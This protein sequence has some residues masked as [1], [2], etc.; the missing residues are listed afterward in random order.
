MK[1]LVFILLF[2]AIVTAIMADQGY[3]ADDK[4]GYTYTGSITG[5]IKNIIN[6]PLLSGTFTLLWNPDTKSGKMSLHMAGGMT[7]CEVT[8][9]DGKSFNGNFTGSYSGFH[10]EGPL[11]GEFGSDSASNIPDSVQGSFDMTVPDQGGAEYIGN[12]HG[13]YR[14]W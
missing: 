2:A 5:R 6:P 4:T 1:K 14:D 12:F 9:R 7:S 10:T 3:P 13:K 8:S 11:Q